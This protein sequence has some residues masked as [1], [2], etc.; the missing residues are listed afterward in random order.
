MRRRLPLLAGLA[1]LPVLLGLGASASQLAVT[2]SSL[3]AT[4]VAPVTP[5]TSGIV[6]ALTNGGTI[7]GQAETADRVTVTFPRALDAST[8]CPAWPAAPTTTQSIVANNAVVVTVA[9]GGTASD[10]L[11]VSSTTCALNLGTTDLGG[12]A[13]TA[14]G[15]LTF[16]GNGTGGRSTIAYDPTTFQVTVVLG[17]RAGTGT[18]GTVAAVTATFTAS[19]SLRYADGTPVVPAT[20]TKTGVQL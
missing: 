8:L 1:A 20:A 16:S 9:D 11:T 19:S 14:G 18:P 10:A 4:M 13:F 12:T 3:T 7:A 6:L 5:P 15:P 17:T 2:P